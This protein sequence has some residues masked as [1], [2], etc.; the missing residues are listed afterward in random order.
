MLSFHDM[1]IYSFIYLAKLRQ[2]LLDPGLGMEP[3]AFCSGNAV[4]TSG[5]HG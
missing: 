5:P 4:L 1:F 2:G 3:P